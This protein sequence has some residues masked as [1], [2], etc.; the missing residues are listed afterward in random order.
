MTMSPKDVAAARTA[1]LARESQA[2]IAYSTKTGDAPGYT[3]PQ[4]QAEARD[5]EAFYEH[6]HTGCVHSIGYCSYYE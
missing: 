1:R 4:F 6:A 5:A 2:R 3:R